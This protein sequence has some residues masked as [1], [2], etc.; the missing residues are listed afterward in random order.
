VTRYLQ[1]IAILGATA[2]WAAMPGQAQAQAAGQWK[3]PTHAY[4]KI[5]GNCHEIGVGPV[6]KGRGLDP[7]Y[8][9]QVARHGMRAMP[10]I[11]VTDI[12]DAML[13]QLANFLSKS[14]PPA[15]GG[16]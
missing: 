6:L 13:H 11:R 5:C 16:K 14:A 1:R 2:V 12:D 10:A 9:V 15:G 4:T 7:D 3:D 8:F